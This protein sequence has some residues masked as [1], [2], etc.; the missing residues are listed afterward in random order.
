MRDAVIGGRTLAV[1][2][3]DMSTL[4][5]AARN[6]EFRR[7]LQRR[8]VTFNDGAG[9]A[10]VARV[11]RRAPF[12]DNLHGTDL[13]PMLLETLP[14]GTTIYVLGAPADVV[15]RAREALENKYPA[16]RFVGHHHGY[17][18]DALEAS[19]LDE[20]RRLRPQVVL[21]GMGNPLQVEFIDRHLDDPDLAGTLWLAIGGQLHYY[22]G[23]LE[24]APA[25][26]IRA[27]LEWLHLVIRQPHKLGRYGFGIPRFIARSL[28]AQLRHGHD[29]SAALR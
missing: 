25:W 8:V 14:S 16:L 19:V 9:L 28:W 3:P 20:L 22:G 26:M 10:F 7:L 1:A 4:N 18:D 5:L 12:P 6:P 27:K 17:L 29:A 24:R 15:D 11:I 2:F 23:G 13:C 21:V